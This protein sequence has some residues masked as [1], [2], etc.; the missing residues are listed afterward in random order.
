[1]IN[2]FNRRILFQDTNAEATASVW[3]K[4]RENGIKYELKTKTHVSS[5]RRTFTQKSNINFNMGGVSAKWTEH[6]AD[7]LYIVYVNRNDFE[8]AKQ[9]CSI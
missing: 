7:Y 4:L 8:K 2:V 5:F 9:V 6:P 1:M 3:S